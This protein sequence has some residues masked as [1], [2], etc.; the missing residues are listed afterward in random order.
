MAFWYSAVND[1]DLDS[2][3]LKAYKVR[4]VDGILGLTTAYEMPKKNFLLP[5]LK[6]ATAEVTQE[7]NEEFCAKHIR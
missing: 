7:K 6:L 4:I 5:V 2:V 1:P 3:T